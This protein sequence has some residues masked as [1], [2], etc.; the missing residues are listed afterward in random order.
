MSDGIDVRHWN[1]DISSDRIR[2]ELG[3]SATAPVI[4]FVA[5][6]D[7]W[8]GLEI[9]LRA[10]KQVVERVPSAHFLIVGD[11]PA[12]FERY[13]DSMVSLSGALGLAKHVHFLG[14]RYRLSDIP[15]VMAALTM[16]CHTSARPEPFGLVVIEAMAVGCPVIAPLAGGPAEIVQENVTGYLVP[17]GEV[18]VFADRICCLIQDPERRARMS[19]AGRERVVREYSSERFTCRLADLYARV[20]SGEFSGAAAR[21]RS[22]YRTSRD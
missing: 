14:W 6:I 3:L 22:G 4:G 18:A 12:G 20:F 15:E 1:P 9:F 16:L 2:R 19:V 5:R 21:S 17:P 13:R 11:A 7:P 8:K 10:A